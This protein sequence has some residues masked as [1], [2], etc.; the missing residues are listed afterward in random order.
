MI[1]FISRGAAI[2]TQLKENEMDNKRKYIPADIELIRLNARD[3]IT[4]S[5]KKEDENVDDDGW[6]QTE[7][8]KDT[9]IW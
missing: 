6:T 4:T 2:N 3:I 8:M 1:T 5:E 7:E 9:S